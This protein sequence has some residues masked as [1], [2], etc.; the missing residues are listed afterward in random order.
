MKG[1]KQGQ[2]FRQL[3][4]QHAREQDEEEV[5]VESI[6]LTLVGMGLCFGLC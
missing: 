4:A 6:L 3:L 5:G 1:L 2:N